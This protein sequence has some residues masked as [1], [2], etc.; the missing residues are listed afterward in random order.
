MRRTL[1][2]VA[3]A[4]VVSACGSS[5]ETSKPS[6]MDRPSP[7]VDLATAARKL[8]GSGTARGV[9]SLRLVPPRQMPLSF[10]S[11]ALSFVDFARRRIHTITGTGLGEHSES[12]V[13]DGKRYTRTLGG[14]V[15]QPDRAG[16]WH[17]ETSVRDGSPAGQFAVVPW[18]A[19]GATRVRRTGARTYRAF[20]HPARAAAAA[21]AADRQ[22]LQT[23][24][25]TTL[26]PKGGPADFVVD[27]RGRLRELR[28][29]NSSVLPGTVIVYTY[30]YSQLGEPVHV[31]APRVG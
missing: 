1:L 26:G 17:R 29:R 14:G 25:T 8:V 16:P 13:V 3:L 6:T 5:S 4:L 2:L 12:I 31:A 22:A 27:G 24:L 18:A 7:P 9:Y 28:L 30:R 11:S 19:A 23:F 10:T 21:P 20:V 15:G